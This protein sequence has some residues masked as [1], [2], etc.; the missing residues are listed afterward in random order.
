MRNRDILREIMYNLKAGKR[1]GKFVVNV[2]YPYFD[3]VLSYSESIYNRA[4]YD[5]ICWSHFG[6]S[7]NKA[8][9]KELNW[10]ITVIFKLSPADFVS[11]YELR[12]D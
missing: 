3:T 5:L 12:E 2:K 4:P 9:L 6:S 10:I 7:A 1:Y 11:I 8:T